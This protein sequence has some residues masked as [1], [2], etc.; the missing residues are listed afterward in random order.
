[1][2]KLLVTLAVVGSLATGYGVIQYQANEKLAV[3]IDKQ[4]TSFEEASGISIN[5]HDASYSLLNNEV[6][7]KDINFK[8]PE[9]EALANI[10]EIIFEGYE[11]DK[12]SPYTFIDLKGLHLTESFISK[13]EHSTPEELLNAR[14]DVSSSLKYDESTQMSDFD[15]SFVA[16]D[17]ATMTMALSMGSA[18]ALMDVSLESQKMKQQGPLTMEQELQLQSKMMTALKML[19][20]KSFNF[21]FN[22]TGQFESVVEQQLAAVNLDKFSFIQQAQLQVDML[23]MTDSQKEQVMNFVNGLSELSISMTLNNAKP[24]SEVAAQVM[25]LAQQPAALTELL[26]L[27]VQGR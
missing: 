27:Q 16:S 10:N 5:Y 18:K 25:G 2:K 19:Q 14:Y 8:D 9:G 21:T 7:I 24:M 13:T 6:S 3:E 20:P 23:P 26:N 1:M 11:A 4:V 12:I 15:F 22:N 17:V